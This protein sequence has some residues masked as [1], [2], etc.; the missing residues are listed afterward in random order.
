MTLSV[1]CRVNEDGNIPDYDDLAAL[2]YQSNGH[3]KVNIGLGRIS[4]QRGKQVG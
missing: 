4:D 2:G 3:A 1:I